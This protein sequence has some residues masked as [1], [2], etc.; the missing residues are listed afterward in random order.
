MSADPNA[1]TA[2][3]RDPYLDAIRAGALLVVVL[4][5]WLATLPVIEAGQ[6]VDTEHLL[7]TWPPAGFFTWVVQ[8]VP[9]FVFVSAAV[10][11]EGSEKRNLSG[12]SQLQWWAGRALGLARPTV[13][14]MVVLVAFVVVSLVLGGRMLE[15]LN[16]SLTVHLWF[17]LLLLG[18]QAL[19]GVCVWADR[20]WGLKVIVGLILFAAVIDLLR[21]SLSAPA[22]VLQFGARVVSDHHLLGWLNVLAIWLVPQ[23]LGIAWGRGRFKAS[24]A[25]PVFLLLGMIWLGL[26]V[27][28]GYPVQMVDGEV[29]GASNLLPPTLALLGVMWLQVG[30][31]LIFEKPVRRFLERGRA[32]R[33]TV[34]LGALGLQLCLWHK[35]AEVPAARVGEWLNFGMGTLPGDAGFWQGRLE[36]LLLC[37]LMVL[38]IMVAVA[39][40]ESR[41]RQDVTAATSTWRIIIGGAALFAGL[42][43]SLV[44]G[45]HPGAF[46]GL[47]GVACASFLLRARAA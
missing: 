36:W 16:N 22:D 32:D 2:R 37:A 24:Q 6:M 13:S 21:A 25:G 45:A 40:F 28:S 17:L 8:V 33:L 34:I 5:H 19:L 46:F 14:Y 29:G 42:G 9:L 3:H 30:A 38:P 47:A 18:V 7:Q 35:L 12:E 41:R 27:T 4:G 20:R 39:W 43:L 15:P 10:S 26:S 23:Q 31:V 1:T 11:S 44:L